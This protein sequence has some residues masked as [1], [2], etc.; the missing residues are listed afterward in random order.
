MLPY[1]IWTT[2]YRVRI[3][4]SA[5]VEAKCI[6]LLFFGF[7][8]RVLL[9]LTYNIFI[10]GLFSVL[11]RRVCSLLLERTSYPTTFSMVLCVGK[12][13]STRRYRWSPF[14]RKRNE[15][16]VDNWSAINGFPRNTIL[17]HQFSRNPRTQNRMGRRCA[18]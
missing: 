5:V 2:E 6:Y 4:H 10:H 3:S 18:I 7:S 8:C 17:P 14:N 11:I 12:T 1:K 13:E 15:W 9:I 16:R